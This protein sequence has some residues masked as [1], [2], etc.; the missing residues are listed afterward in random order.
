MYKMGKSIYRIFVLLFILASCRTPRHSEVVYFESLVME[1]VGDIKPDTAIEVVIFPYKQV[2]EKEMT[3]KLAFSEFAIEKSIPD[4]SLNR[5][6]ADLIFMS[7][8][9]FLTMNDSLKLDFALLNY[10][11]LR[12]SL[13]K[14]EITVGDI[15]ELMPFD[16]MIGIAELDAETVK[17]LF[18]FLAQHNDGHPI[19]NASF[20]IE[21]EKAI[22]ILIAGESLDDNRTYLVATND[23]LLSGND[24]MLFFAKSLKIINTNIMVR[25]AILDN[26]GKFNLNLYKNTLENQRLKIK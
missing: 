11:G 16:N 22:N 10:G 26:I 7:A 14:G 13:P 2:L 3:K 9:E 23:Y 24:G 1:A 4:G 19:A 5:L 12:N 21:N 8:R 17:E 25:T 18:G 20:E 15:Y 6:T